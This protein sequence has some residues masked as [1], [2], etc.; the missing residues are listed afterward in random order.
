MKNRNGWSESEIEIIKTFY[1]SEGP[2][3]LADRLKN[4]RSKKS[5]IAKAFRLKLISKAPRKT[6]GMVGT[7]T[8]KAWYSCIQRCTNKNHPEADKYLGAGI[9]VCDE[10]IGSFVAFMNDMGEAPT[11]KHIIDRIE[12]KKG[13]E[14]GNCRWVTPRQSCANTRKK[15]NSNSPYKGISKLPSGKW[16]ALVNRLNAPR[17]VGIFACPKEA[18]IAYDIAAEQEFGQ[19]AMTNKRLGL[20]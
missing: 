17:Q 18:A 15:S 1:E 12:P 9:K 5:I 8:Y 19:Y 3:G 2:S 4:N 20:L 6:H 10:W 7:R 13:Y 16:R 14:P 11:D